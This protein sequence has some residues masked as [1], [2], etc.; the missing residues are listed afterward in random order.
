ML[1]NEPKLEEVDILLGANMREDERMGDEGLEIILQD[2]D[3]AMIIC[4]HCDCP[5][6]TDL[7]NYCP[8][9]NHPA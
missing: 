1:N 3:P 7:Y 6:D 9:C 8:V 2:A 4:N 5:F